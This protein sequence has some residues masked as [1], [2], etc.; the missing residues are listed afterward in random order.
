MKK[1]I[2]LSG[3]MY[4]GEKKWR[5][6]CFWY[7]IAYAALIWNMAIQRG[8]YTWEVFFPVKILAFF[9]AWL[10]GSVNYGIAH[11]EKIKHEKVL[12]L[13]KNIVFFLGVFGSIITI[14][15]MSAILNIDLLW[16][17]F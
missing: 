14:I 17:M 13:R 1:N 11:K 2:L 4:I 7:I 15:F 12:S 3:I 6:Y 8:H 5:S 16:L 9:T 10:Y